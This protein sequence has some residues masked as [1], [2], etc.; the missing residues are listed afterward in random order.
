GALAINATHEAAAVIFLFL[1]GELLEGVAA[2]KARDSIKSLAGL[3]PKTALLEEDGIVREVQAETLT[4][5]SVV[6][7][8]PGDRVSADGI[9][10]SGKGFVDEAPITGESVP[11]W[12]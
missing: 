10:M 7:V 8:R 11:V 2:G 3:V 1:V 5:G 9:I 6:L 4:I 12:K